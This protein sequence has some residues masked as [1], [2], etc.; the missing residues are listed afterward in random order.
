MRIEAGYD[1]GFNCP[2]KVPMGLMLSVHPSRR[3]DL[4]TEHRIR[5]S[6][7][8]RSRDYL[9]SFGN[10]CTRLVAPP[11]LLEVRTQFLIRDGGLPDEVPPHAPQVPVDELP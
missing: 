1:I 7:G 2:Q 10:I 3:H 11:G 4:L 6:P 5:F 9:D 8:I